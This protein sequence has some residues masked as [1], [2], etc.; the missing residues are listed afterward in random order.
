MSMEGE[1]VSRRNLGLLSLGLAAAVVGK[2]SGCSPFPLTQGPSHNKLLQTS[3]VGWFK[4]LWQQTSCKV[5]MGRAS[6]DPINLHHCNQSH[7]RNLPNHPQRAHPPSSSDRGQP[8]SHPR[9][10][11]GS[12]TGGDVRRRAALPDRKLLPLPPGPYGLRTTLP[13]RDHSQVDMPCRA[14]AVKIRQL[15]SGKQHGFTRPLSRTAW[16]TRMVSSNSRNSARG[17]RR[18]VP[19]FIFFRFFEFCRSFRSFRSFRS[20][21]SF[22]SFTFPTVDTVD[23]RYKS[24]NSVVGTGMNSSHLRH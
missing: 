13:P 5:P 21:Q 9:P 20:L 8:C 3:R 1:R 10:S 22:I 19:P 12:G 18:R 23:P 4:F 24:V 17:R 16:L 14:L 7:P 11:P 6:I 2:P 15:W